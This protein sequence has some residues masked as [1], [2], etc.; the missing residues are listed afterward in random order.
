MNNVQGTREREVEGPVPAL[1]REGLTEANDALPSDRGF[2]PTANQILR[3]KRDED[4]IEI[5]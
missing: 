3:S 1:V 2:P 4:Q 5:R